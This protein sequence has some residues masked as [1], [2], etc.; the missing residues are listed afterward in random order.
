M[1]DIVEMG[2]VPLK[3]FGLGEVECS[4]GK[5]ISIPIE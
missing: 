2:N 1:E 4:L 5:L 3:L